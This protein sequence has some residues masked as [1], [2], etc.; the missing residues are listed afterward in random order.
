MLYLAIPKRTGKDIYSRTRSSRSL[1]EDVSP[2]PGRREK[3]DEI[4]GYGV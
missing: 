3:T 2:C 4:T 1:R